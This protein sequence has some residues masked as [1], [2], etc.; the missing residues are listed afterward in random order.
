MAF[1]TGQHETTRLCLEALEER[2]VSGATVLDLGCGSGILAIA[3][4][5]LGA[6]CVDALDVDPVCVRVC[7]ENVGRNGVEVRVAEGSLGEAWPFDESAR[8]RY[9]LIL[10]NIS[11]RVIQQF[12]ASIVAALRPEGLAL[13]SGIMGEQQAACEAALRAADADVIDVR[14]DG[15]WRHLIATKR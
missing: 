6:G 13:V 12:A 15:D 9:D 14:R 11:S 8:D 1:G 7:K 5:R 2:L 3:A 4:A 10:A